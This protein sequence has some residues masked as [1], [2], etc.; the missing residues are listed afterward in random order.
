MLWH[1]GDVVGQG[2]SLVTGLGG[3]ESEELRKGLTVLSILVNAKLDVLAESSVEF[4]E[5]FTIFCDLVEQLESLL[6]NVLLNNLHDLVLLKGFTR[7]VQGQ[8]L[9]VNNTFDKAEPFGDEVGR[10]VSDED[11]SDVEL[12]V[13][14][15]LLGLEKVEGST[16]WYEEDGTEF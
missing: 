2:G 8:I 7:Q 5:L 12:D 15:G 4:V 14:L 1:T 10:I 16:L 6:D 3:A 9:R 11:T 13:I